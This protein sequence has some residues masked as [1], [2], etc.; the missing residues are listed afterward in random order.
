MNL[1]LRVANYITRYAP[2]KKKLS[3][4]L[5]KKGVVD[6]E[7]FLHDIGY[8]EEMMLDVWMRTWIAVGKG[9]REIEQKLRT[10]EF[11]P[12]LI[13]SMKDTYDTDIHDWDGYSRSIIHQMDTL[14]SRGKSL[15]Y[16]ERAL[17]QK[18]PYFSEEIRDLREGLDDED[19]LK[20]E[21]QK[22]KNRYN[23]QEKGDIQKFYRALMWKGFAYT[24]IKRILKDQ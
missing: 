20:K 7:S 12:E 6:S 2:S 17:Q 19:S 1:R 16:I 13:E 11:S 15:Q 5:Q 3:L 4:Y 22:Y 8:T 9:K 18:Y 14:R 21:V 10:K 24:D 23:L